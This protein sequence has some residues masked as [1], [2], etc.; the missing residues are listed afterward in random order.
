MPLKTTH[1]TYNVYHVSALFS[2]E[3]FSHEEAE[4]I[5]LITYW[6]HTQ[7]VCCHQMSLSRNHHGHKYRFLGNTGVRK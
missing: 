6:V 5:S 1:C 2:H 3:L 7:E 4:E